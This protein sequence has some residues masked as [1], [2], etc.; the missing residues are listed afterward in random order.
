MTNP[1]TPL[2]A[3]ITTKAARPGG[4]AVADVRGHSDKS[5]YTSCANLVAKGLLFRAKISTARVRY[6]AT[7]VAADAYKR[8]EARKRMSPAVSLGAKPAPV[9]TRRPVEIVMPAGVKVQ[10]VASPAYT[11]LDMSS[12]LRDC[13]VGAARRTCHVVREVAL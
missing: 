6:F 13:A 1:L 5:A 12:M 3:Q 9:K 7:Q 8:T 10:V 2:D 11:R 4:F